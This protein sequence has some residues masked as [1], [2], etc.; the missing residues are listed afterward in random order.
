M[1][2]EIRRSAALFCGCLLVGVAASAADSSYLQPPQD[3]LAILDAQAPPTAELSPDR[4]WVVSIEQDKSVQSIAALAEPL[5][6]LAGMKIRPNVDTQIENAGITRLTLKSL[7]GRTARVVM[8][9]AGGRITEVA[10]VRD[11]ASSGLFAYLTVH[12]GAM[13]LHWYDVAAGKDKVVPTPG[14][15]G[16]LAN[17]R[18]TRDGRYLAFTIAAEKALVLAI[19]DTAAGKATIVDDVAPS[20]TLVF[21]SNTLLGPSW[22]GMDWTAGRPP[23]LVQAVPQDRGPPPRPRV[24]P[25]GPIVQESAG[26]GRPWRTYA[27]LLKAPDDETL[28]DYYLTTQIVAVGV[29][30]RASPV[31]RP[32]LHTQVSSSPD[33]KYLLMGTVHRPY[34]YQVTHENFPKRTSVWTADGHEVLVVLDTP[35]RGEPVGRDA[36]HEGRRDIAWRPDAP[37]TLTWV[38]ALDGG[39]PGKAASK[40]DRLSMLCAPFTGSATVLAESEWR[41][42]ATNWLVPKLALVVEGSSRLARVRVWMIDPQ[43]PAAQSRLLW[44]RSIED[45]YSHPGAFVMVEHPGEARKV[46]LRS[47]DGRSL[48]LVGDGAAADG[49]RPFL[50]RFD[51]ETG[52]TQRLWQSS[53]PWFEKV[54]MS[55]DGS[56]AVLDADA[57]QLLLSRESPTQRPNM[58]VY[59]RSR[60]HLQQLTQLPESS[61][62]LARVRGELLRYKRKDGV[63]LSATLYLPP[64]YDKGRDGPL[65][66]LLWAYPTEFL[67]SAGASQTSDSPFRF[68]RPEVGIDNQY[69]LLLARGYGV[70]DQPTMPIVSRGGAEPNDEYVTQLVAA[71]QAAVDTLATMGVAD[72]KRIGVGGHSYGAFMTANL[73]AHSDLFRAGIARS[74]AYN[75]TLTPFGFQGEPRT[76]WQA[77]D[78]YR[79][80][81][82]FNFVD[83]VKEPI[84]IIHGTHDSNSGTFPVQS[85]RMFAA[86]AGTGGNVRYV[87]LPLEDHRYTARESQRHVLWEMLTWLDRYVKNPG[88]S[89]T[90]SR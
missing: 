77:Q 10:W 79:A 22:N 8:P 26:A 63:D 62:W 51:I 38:E 31:G 16:K 53:A 71:A 74:G 1:R 12:E 5:L 4:H 86:I 2:A 73:L 72:P 9:P 48:Y 21:P 81:S 28:F 46:P 59:T 52:K 89:A 35:L 23:L 43:N 67:T 60:N 50:D 84:L 13:V 54:A 15:R 7:D 19:A 25:T 47:S 69:L 3:V 75:R 56:A 78:V 64:G 20:N 42:R 32:G 65:P 45:L 80:M 90:V 11:P 82:P 66:F 58:F 24:V 18:L 6:T 37:A 14:A 76:Y 44:D 29:D 40:R 55:A 85:E 30:G 88:Q 17:L 36:V 83:A 57:K 39:D 34:S 27:N 33:G 87:Q 61:P 70:L 49:A 41:I 68:R